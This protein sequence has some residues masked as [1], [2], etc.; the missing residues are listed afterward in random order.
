MCSPGVVDAETTASPA[1]ASGAGTGSVRGDVAREAALASYRRERSSTV[2]AAAALSNTTV[3]ARRPTTRV[4]Y[5]RSG[6]I[7][8]VETTRVRPSNVRARSAAMAAERAGSTDASGSSAITIS[9]SWYR[10]RAIA[11]RCCSPPE[12]RSSR[13]CS[14]PSMPSCART[15]PIRSASARETSAR[16][17]PSSDRRPSRPA[18]TFCMTVACGTS[19]SCWYTV[20]IRA[21]SARRPRPDSRATGCPST[22][23]AP[24][25]GASEVLR[26]RSSVDFPAPLGPTMATRSP[27]VTARVVGASA[28]SDPYRRDAPA[29]TSAGNAEAASCGAPGRRRSAGAPSV[30]T[31]PL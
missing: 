29:S 31:R 23:T 27:R 12:S 14:L 15:A 22:S 5:G 3:P 9:G 13:S 7:R 26:R 2:S 18:T 28:S 19:Q 20:P 1:G 8:W 16:S 25:V 11:T 4:T 17:A 21:R 10:V 30:G 6:S 24:V